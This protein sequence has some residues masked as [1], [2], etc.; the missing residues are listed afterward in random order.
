MTSTA[1][2]GAIPPEPEALT[3]VAAKVTQERL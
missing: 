1:H 2:F 3:I